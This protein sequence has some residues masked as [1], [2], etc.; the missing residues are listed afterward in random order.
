MRVVLLGDWFGGSVGCGMDGIGDNTGWY[1][2]SAIQETI[3]YFR[4]PFI[5]YFMGYR[6]LELRTSKRLLSL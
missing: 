6:I 4:I 2:S 5:T 3:R 1:Y